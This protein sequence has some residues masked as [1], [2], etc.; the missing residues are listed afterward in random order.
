MF[1]QKSELINYKEIVADVNE[2][3]NEMYALMGKIN[4]LVNEKVVEI[5]EA[6][7]QSEE[8]FTDE[9][10]SLLAYKAEL[11]RIE[12]RNFFTQK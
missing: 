8:I 2:R 11:K 4:T 5:E 3:A 10:T 9:I 12:E 1:E 7:G 6:A